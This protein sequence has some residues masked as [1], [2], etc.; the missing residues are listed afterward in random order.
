MLQITQQDLFHEFWTNFRIS[1]NLGRRWKFELNLEMEIG[2][3]F[4][5]N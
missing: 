3:K 5:N 1:M 4:E 2:L